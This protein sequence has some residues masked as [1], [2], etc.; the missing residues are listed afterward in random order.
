MIDTGI[1]PRYCDSN[2]IKPI[3]V[4]QI[5]E[6]VADKLQKPTS[7]NPISLAGGALQ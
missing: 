1:Q 2:A 3:S 4:V 5:T 7:L 6:A